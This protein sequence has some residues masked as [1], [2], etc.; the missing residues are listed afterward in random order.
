MLLKNRIISGIM[1]LNLIFVF[2]DIQKK[3]P[4]MFKKTPIFDIAYPIFYHIALGVIISFLAKYFDVNIT[5]PPVGTI[6]LVISYVFFLISM[7]FRFLSMI[8]ET[9]GEY[10]YEESMWKTWSKFNI[11]RSVTL[12]TLFIAAILVY[13]QI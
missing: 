6:I 3:G 8:I 4:I 2:I 13:N 5:V 1:V 11:M 9:K 7:V 12:I 10:G